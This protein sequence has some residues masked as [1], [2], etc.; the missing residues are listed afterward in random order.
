MGV[1]DP[2]CVLLLGDSEPLAFLAK[3]IAASDD[4]CVAQFASPAEFREGA[5]HSPALVVADLRAEPDPSG[6]AARLREGGPGE[7]SPLLLLCAAD[8]SATLPVLPGVDCIREPV[9]RDELANRVLLLLSAYRLGRRRGAETPSATDEAIL[10]E[11]EARFR[12]M[13]DSAP[14]MIWQAGSD[15]AC[16][17]FNQPWLRFTGRTLADES[18]SGWMRHLHP[19]DATHCVEIRTHSF[20]SREPFTVEYRLRRADGQYRWVLDTGVPLIDGEFQGYIGSAIDITEQKNLEDE[21]RA[22]ADALAERDRHRDEFLAMLAHELRNPLGAISNAM[23]ALN[24]AGTDGALSMRMRSIIERQSGHLARLVDDLLDVSRLTRGVIVLR[25]ERTDLAA[26]VTAAAEACRAAI[27]ARDHRLT[28]NL[29]SEHV[30]VE[31]D[32]A[33]LEQ[34]ISNL[35]SNAV[36]YTDPGG[37]IQL[38]AEAEQREDGRWAVIRV[39]DDGAGMSPELIPRVFDLFTQAERLLD[40]SQGGLGIGLTLVRR[41]V[42]MHGGT[43]EAR[44]SGVGLGSEFIVRLPG[45]SSAQ[46]EARVEN[47]PRPAHS[48][49]LRV[50]VVEDNRDSAETLGE[51]LQLWGHEP[52]IVYDGEAALRAVADGTPPDVVLLDI[53]LPGMDGYEVARR[54]RA[55]DGPALPLVALT[56]YGQEEDRARSAAAG[57]DRHIVKPPN[58]AMLQRCLEEVTARPRES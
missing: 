21:L 38:T 28:L 26:M 55:S 52:S 44:S 32:P 49:G 58:A 3:V 1:S 27:Q 13:A 48:R 29:P 43:V 40:R 18:G 54:L 31:V 33:R 51:L 41:L 36:K 53:G 34:I 45:V 6:A 37:L 19:D 8:D 10:R 17:W 57:F 56:G 2:T 50:L 7:H 46:L 20:A 15:G 24:Y 5:C 22:H 47:F 25:K 23:A 4:A 42:E 9:D 16:H 14:V 11:S 12:T 39:K 35:I 30:S